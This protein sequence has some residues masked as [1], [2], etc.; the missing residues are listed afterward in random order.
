LS[1]RMGMQ[2]EVC[3]AL[4]DPSSSENHAQIDSSASWIYKGYTKVSSSSLALFMQVTC[5]CSVLE[6]A[7]KGIYDVGHVGAIPHER[8]RHPE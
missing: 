8:F 5:K 7:V 1:S 2:T 4:S 6:G 3:T